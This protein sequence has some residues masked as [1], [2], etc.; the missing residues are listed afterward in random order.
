ML[1]DRAHFSLCLCDAYAG[2]QPRDPNHAGV[3]STSFQEQRVVLAERQVHVGLVQ[4]A[5]KRREHS[6]DDVVRPTQDHGFSERLWACL[7]AVS[8]QTIADDDHGRSSVPVFLGSEL[9]AKT[10]RHAK[11]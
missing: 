4:E 11:G 2:V 5:K 7:K 3:A 8:P 6:Y 9:A 10:W 1:L